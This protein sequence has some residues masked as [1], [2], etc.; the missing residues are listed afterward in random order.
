HHA[1]L[2]DRVAATRRFDLDHLGAEVGQHRAGE[3][4]GDQLAQFEYAKPFEGTGWES[5]S[6]RRGSCTGGSADDKPE[7]RGRPPP[8]PDAS[9]RF[10]PVRSDRRWDPAPSP[11]SPG[12]PRAGSM[13]ATARAP[14]S[15]TPAPL[16]S[17]AARISP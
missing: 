7:I 1:P 11:A 10:G 15:P 13:P 2:A 8:A 3:G 9:L 17:W 4:A 6:H 12:P 14:A 16:A 5:V